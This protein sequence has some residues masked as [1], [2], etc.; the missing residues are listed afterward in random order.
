[1]ENLTVSPKFQVVIPSEIREL[2]DIYA[3]QKVVVLQKH[4]I[5]HIIPVEDVK[6]MRGRYKA[7]GLTSEGMRDETDRF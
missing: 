6:T 2:L 5:I 7:A 4:G 3:G 1:M